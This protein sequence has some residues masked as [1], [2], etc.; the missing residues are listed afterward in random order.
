MSSPFKVKEFTFGHRDGIYTVLDV[1]CVPTFVETIV[2]PVGEDWAFDVQHYRRH[3]QISVSPTGRS[4]QVF[5][6]GRRIP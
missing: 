1:S 3:I 5:V 2:P 6:D 4:V